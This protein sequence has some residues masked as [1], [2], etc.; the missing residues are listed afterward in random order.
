VYESD[1]HNHAAEHDMIADEQF[2]QS[3]KAAVRDDPSRPVKR[4][5]DAA[6]SDVRRQGRQRDRQHVREFRSLRS[7]L[8]RAKRESV[9]RIPRSI[10]HVHIV[11]PWADTWSDERFLLCNDRHWGIAA[12]ATDENLEILQKCKEV[13][14]D[15]TFRSTP[16]PY[17]QFVTIHGKFDGRVLCLV[18]CLMGGKTTGH[19][20]QVF[21]CL[22]TAVRRLTR[23]RLKPRRIVCD[24]EQAIILAAETE[25]PR[26]AISGCYFH[27]CQSL[28]RKI[29]TLGLTT[30][31]GTDLRLQKSIRM[32]MSI[33]YLPVAVVRH[34]FTQFC[35]SQNFN[36]L[37]TTYPQLDDFVEY[38]SS[39]YFNGPFPPVMW[40]I[41][42]R[43][44]S[45]RT[46][47]HVE[48]MALMNVV[49]SQFQFVR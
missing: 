33:G 30:Q 39:T 1:I 32:L 12:F 29:Q 37:S 49:F 22:K 46:N 28:Y 47:N 17:K 45:N 34:T 3:A 44:S 26:V 8:S 25:F 15:G 42:T 21:Q 6:V 23:R 43:D 35:Q 14:I 2:R 10:D 36:V 27:F 9:P 18:S 31:Y 40:N 7:A 38:I 16:P 13:Y 4:A 41:Y 11:S 20:R 24:F 5:F 48:G 19:Y